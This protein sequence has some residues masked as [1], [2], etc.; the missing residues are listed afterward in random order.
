M[1]HV[2]VLAA[3]AL[4][5]LGL[6]WPLP[7]NLSTHLTG[8]PGGDTGVYVW[9]LWLFRHELM[10]GRDPFY[11]SALFAPTGRADLAFHNYTVFANVLSLPLQPWLGLIATFNVLYL[12]LGVLNAY[13]MFLLAR[14]LSRDVL[15]AWLAGVLFAFSPFLTARGT[16][17]FS[18][19]AA[20]PLPIF[21]LL[22]LKLEAT[23]QVRHAVGAGLTLAWAVY[24][25][26]YY[27][28]FCVLIATVHL[29]FTMMRVARRPRAP[30]RVLVRAIDAVALLLIALTAWIALT[31]G[32]VVSIAGLRVGL[33]STNTPILLT[34][35]LVAVRLPLGLSLRPSIREGFSRRAWA[36]HAGVAMLAAAALLLPFIHAVATRMAEGEMVSPPTYWR[37]SPKG[38]DALAFLMPNPNHQLF[39]ASAHEWLQRERADGFAENAAA[40]TMVAPIVIALGFRRFRALPPRWTFL[41]AFFAL[42]ALGP[43]VWVGG[44]NTRIPT[45]WALLR[46]VPGIGLVRS[47]S[48]FAVVVIMAVAV[49]FAL[50]LTALQRRYP[51]GRGALL[52]GVGALLL[53]ELAPLPR[54]LF[55]AE[56]PRVFRTI[57]DDPRDIRVLELP[58]GLRDGTLSTG[59]Y[60]ASAQFHQTLH[61]K[62]IFGGYLSRVST[63]R[64]RACRKFP[65]MDALIAVSAGESLTPQQRRRAF[66]YRTR[67]L[68]RSRVGYVVIDNSRTSERLRRFAIRLLALEKVGQDGSYELY[69]SDGAILEADD[70][71]WVDQ[72]LPSPSSSRSSEELAVRRLAGGL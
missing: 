59:N 14:H 9:N 17:H 51:R 71:P 45:P 32:T 58:T 70:E 13:A 25:D 12:A 34:A 66:A 40:L 65:V 39:G 24:C 60:G 10:Q 19:V 20:A 67:F 23:H 6:S 63:R 8:D 47:P 72:W 49:L 26:P 5:S 3:Y 33:R 30:S 1:V 69:V 61:G 29:G 41:A 55:S 22:L 46:Y 43:F 53:F 48:R 37:S 35:L 52:A 64:I 44:W 38:V 18:L 16:A 27:A 62:A 56:I 50:A 36:D 4:L 57:A 28:V 21:L 11:T 15:T 7:L 68:Q 2:A 42:L 31:G 54:P